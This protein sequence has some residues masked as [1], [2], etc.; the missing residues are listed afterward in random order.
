[1]D[2]SSRV[3][4][5]RSVVEDLIHAADDAWAY[6]RWGSPAAWLSIATR[7]HL[8]AAIASAVLTAG[9]WEPEAEC[10]DCGALLPDGDSVCQECRSIAAAEIEADLEAAQR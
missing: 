5:P 9:D 6:R 10:I 1:M 3:T 8:S 7:L 4:L 2:N